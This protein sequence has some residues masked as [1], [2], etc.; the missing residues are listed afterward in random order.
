MKTFLLIII[1]LSSIPTV[2]AQDSIPVKCGTI[3]EYEFTESYQPQNF[4][5][6]LNAGTQ[7]RV[8]GSPLGDTL[9]LSI[10]IFAPNGG[11]I[12]ANDLDGPYS[13]P[14]KE[15]FTE[16]GVVSANGTYTIMAYNG[17]FYSNR[18]WSDN[19]DYG[20]GVYTLYI[21]CTLR[22]GT[23]IE[24][25]QDPTENPDLAATV[26]PTEF[27]V[28][29]FGFPGLGPVDFSKGIEIPLSLGEP[30]TA[31]IANDVALYT[32][33]A[34][35]DETATLS[36]SRVSGDISIGVTVIK[37]EANEI[38]F[39]GGLPSSNNLSVELTFPTEGAYAIGLFR[40]DTPEHSGTAG[41]VQIILG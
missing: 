7:L 30:Q 35:A 17:Y 19:R 10:G 34:S 36:I 25:G 11:M 20:V 29:G 32:Y 21:S 23:V 24:A 16:S 15:P 28:D 27:P 31:P 14:E 5:I 38:I 40:L 2:M 8:G 1:L 26:V 33:I 18:P 3:I 41:A 39:L 6:E 9:D 12:A 4:S 37:K 13:Y 22:D